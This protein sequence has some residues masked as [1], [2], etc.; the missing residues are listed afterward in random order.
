MSSRVVGRAAGHVDRGL[1]AL[2]SRHADRPRHDVDRDRYRGAALSVGFDMYLSRV[3]G[4][5]WLVGVFAFGTVLF[6]GSA[7]SVSVAE[8]AGRIATVV[9]PE[10]VSPAPGS[11]LILLGLAFGLFAKRLTVTAGGTYLRWRAS[12][13]RASIER[14]LPGAARYLRAL[15]DGSESRHEMVRTV[16]EQD[17]YGEASTSFERVL[18]TAALTGSLDT[19]LRRIARETPSRGML[20]PFLLRFREHAGG[21]AESL[22][23]YL[24]RE[25]R[26]LSH[27]RSRARQRA[28]EYTDLLAELFLFVL[29]LP[30]LLVVVA[31][32]TAAL[33]VGP[34][35]ATPLPGSPTVEGLLVY[36]GSAFVI[37]A[38]G[39]TAFLVAELRPP[40]HARTYERPTGI[41]TVTTAATN[42]ASAAFVFAFPA[43]VVAWLLWLSGEPTTDAVLLG[44]SAYG[45]PVGAVAV[46]R[47]RLD[48]AKD[49]EIRE[50]VHAVA[51][52]VGL[53]NPLGTAVRRAADG[54]DVRVLRADIDDL[55]FRLSLTA[56]PDAGD[57]RRAAL[58]RFLDRV[59][60]PLA[61]QTVGL[62]TGAIDVGSDAETTF[63]TLQAEIGS[64]YHQRKQLR[65]A[66]LV[67]VV[68]GWT[69]AVLLLAVVLAVDVFLLEWFVRVGEQTGTGA[70]I[71][72]DVVDASGWR[73]YL[74]TQATMLACGWFVGVASRGRY[75]A[76]FHSAALVMICYISFA[77]AGVV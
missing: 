41:A 13:R 58:D 29:V 12:A 42:P 64:L 66:M 25:S 40:D 32:I 72:R 26:M 53:G 47:E 11:F 38:G 5:S 4:L 65:S 35:G 8:T 15:A 14:S 21:G 68:I 77:G 36:G 60:T 57:A 1:Y 75:E 52:H 2:F 45:F 28:G 19:G 54:V 24:R 9:L 55:V 17:A 73:F 70:A 62:V 30:A 43:A 50:F 63:E 61:E 34:S 37:V 74:V 18:E 76:L 20:S 16:A 22:Q 46:K 39:A 3:Y 69:T 44:Y 6:V 31:T 10:A 49:R 48:D 59:G 51:G 71:D 33:T 23:G 67:Y 27:Q 7:P 56:A